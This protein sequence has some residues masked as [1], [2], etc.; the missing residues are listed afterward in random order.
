MQVKTVGPGGQPHNVTHYQKTAVETSSVSALC[1]EEI[2]YTQI[3]DN[4]AG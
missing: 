2:L 4:D 3:L 1:G